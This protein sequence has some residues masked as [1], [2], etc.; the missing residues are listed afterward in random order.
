[1]KIIAVEGVDRLIVVRLRDLGHDVQWIAE[2][3]PSDKD[4]EVL[5][6]AV[7]AKALL[8]TEDKD[9][10]ELVFRKD[11]RHTGN[12]FLRLDGCSNAVKADWV[13]EVI[14]TYGR[15]L[16]G[17]FSVLTPDAIRIRPDP[18]SEGESP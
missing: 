5:A 4:P 6:R 10:G 12:L 15:R 7:E 13:L 11:A 3:A 8:I 2:V 9:F 14:E 18:G 1:M 16:L 17:A